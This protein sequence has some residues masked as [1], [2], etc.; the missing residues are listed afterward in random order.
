MLQSSLKNKSQ[1]HFLEK[2]FWPADSKKSLK[3]R[4]A[5]FE[6][7]LSYGVWDSP[8]KHD[9]AVGPKAVSSL[10]REIM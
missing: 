4:S 8:F 9:P 10:L 6:M 7:Q 3:L 1:S 5:A 2:I